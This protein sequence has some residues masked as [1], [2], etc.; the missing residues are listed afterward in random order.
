MII[1]FAFSKAVIS[2]SFVMLAA[3]WLFD[4]NL[5]DKLK[6]FFQNKTAFYFSFIYFIF[7]FGLIY[8]KNFDVAFGDLKTKLPFLAFPLIISTSPKLSPKDFKFMMLIFVVSITASISVSLFNILFTDV[9]FFRKAFPFISHIRLS[10]AVVVSLSILFF[11]SI[12]QNSK[13][14]YEILIYIL[15]AIYLSFSMIVL[16][17]M[18]GVVLLSILVISTLVYMLIKNRKFAKI[19]MFFIVLFNMVVIYI[20]VYE[21]K[22]YFGHFNKDENKV[23]ELTI[24]GNSYSQINYLPYENGR[25]IGLNVCWIE[26]EKEWEKK[27]GF[28]FNSQ[29]LSE[30]QLKYTIIRY[31]NSKGLSKDSVGISKLSDKD[32]SYIERGIANYE[33]INDLS[34][35]K[36]LYKIF[37]EIG[38]KSRGASI[39]GHSVLQRFLLWET[40]IELISDNPLFGVGTGDITDEFEEQL[41][42]KGFSLKKFN[43]RPHNQFLS[44]FV[45]YGIIGGL[46]IV[47]LIFYPPI[48]LN[49][50]NSY[51]FL[52]FFVTMIFSMLWEDTVES[53]V[54]VTMFMFLYCLH[55]FGIDQSVNAEIK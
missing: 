17:L 27:S 22:S 33:Y 40:A 7:L 55:L 4:K 48:K 54:G 53:Q 20:V 29:D 51:L 31:L 45:T 21:Y 39:A 44:F 30:Q 52:S 13:L 6:Y 35:K 26:L 16:E 42:N 47:F 25:K 12:N 46:I 49:A 19:I 38:L 10:L 2:I 9:L 43:Y 34:Y 23:K 41:L 37:W 14:K 15:L 24:N 32:I 8:T 1:G 50:F 11:Y 3:N 18:T 28:K 36:R 5:F